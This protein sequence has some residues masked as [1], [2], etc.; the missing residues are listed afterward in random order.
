MQ[1]EVEN[2][3]YR[4]P[5]RG[6]GHAARGVG[7]GI[8]CVIAR[9]VHEAPATCLHPVLACLRSVLVPVHLQSV[10][11]VSQVSRHGPGEV[12]LQ[13]SVHAA[14]GELARAFLSLEVGYGAVGSVTEEHELQSV[15]TQPGV[16]VV[17]VAHGLYSLVDVKSL[18][19]Y[20]VLVFT[21][22]GS[23]SGATQRPSVYVWVYAPVLGGFRRAMPRSSPT[24]LS[25]PGR[26]RMSGLSAFG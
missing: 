11:V 20:G 7:E 25:P 23:Q 6:I 9:L 1:P 15:E 14:A 5:I 22:E 19:E 2:G 18:G 12:Q 24:R 4:S 16:L 10:G 26:W 3:G 13:G 8:A 21:Q 17:V